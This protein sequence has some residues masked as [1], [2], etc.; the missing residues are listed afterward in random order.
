MNRVRR[1]HAM[2][3]SQ[4][5]RPAKRRRQRQ[6]TAQEELQAIIRWLALN[7]TAYQRTYQKAYRAL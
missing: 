2:C 7:Q 3:A 5:L 4:K 6:W 1:Y